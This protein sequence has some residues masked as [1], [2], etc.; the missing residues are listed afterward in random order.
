M[1]TYLVL[2]R[3]SVKEVL[4]KEEILILDTLITKIREYEGYRKYEV[5]EIKKASN[6][7]DEEGGEKL[8]VKQEPKSKSKPKPEPRQC[9]YN[10]PWVGICKNRAMEGSPNC[11]QHQDLCGVC[12]K[13]LATHGCSCAGSFVCGAPLCDDEV[14]IKKHWSKH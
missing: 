5:T 7:L 6:V 3:D 10:E 12:H 1:S 9:R 11:K 2:D 8:E 4:T 13:N 14:C